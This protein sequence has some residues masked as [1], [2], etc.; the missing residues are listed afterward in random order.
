MSHEVRARLHGN[1]LDVVDL[2]EHCTPATL[3]AF[4]HQSDSHER[5]AI[6]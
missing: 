4:L 1:D 3:A 2:F 5:K 6:Q